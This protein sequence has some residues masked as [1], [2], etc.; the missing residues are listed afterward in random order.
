MRRVRC[1]LIP[2]V[3]MHVTIGKCFKTFMSNLESA[4]ASR[5]LVDMILLHH[6]TNRLAGERRRH[7]PITAHAKRH[8]VDVCRARTD[9]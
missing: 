5:Q 8:R 4:S 7:A 2:R 1:I 6:A 3:A 9:Y